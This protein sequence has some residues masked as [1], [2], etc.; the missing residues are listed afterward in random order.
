LSR[1]GL[2]RV[3]AHPQSSGAALSAGLAAV[4]KLTAAGLTRIAI[5]SPSIGQS[6]LGPNSATLPPTGL[7]SWVLRFR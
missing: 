1:S 6:L 4:I 7:L 3:L 2:S 5:V